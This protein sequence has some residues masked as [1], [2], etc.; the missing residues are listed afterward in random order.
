M[1]IFE[2][3]KLNLG[4]KKIRKERRKQKEN[5]KKLQKELENYKIK[6]KNKYQELWDIEIEV[7]AFKEQ[8]KQIDDFIQ[9]SDDA[10]INEIFMS[11]FYENEINIREEKIL[12]IENTISDYK[13][14]IYELNKAINSNKKTEEKNAS[15]EN[16]LNITK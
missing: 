11:D 9:N 3:I 2:D 6:I 12:E 15:E 5:E 14:K 4:L 7:N 16:D 1:S 10:N 13:T 8:K